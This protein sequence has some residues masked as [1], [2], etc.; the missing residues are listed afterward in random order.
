MDEPRN[1]A[2][3]ITLFDGP[4]NLCFGCSPF[5]ERGLRLVW[6][7]ANGEVR[8]RY[9]VPH[10]M[11]GAPGVAHG[12]IQAAL[13]DE[14]LGVAIHTALGEGDDV[15]YVTADF[16]LRYRRPVMTGVPVE[17]AGRLERREG[18]NHFVAGEI[19]ALDGSVLT[20]ATARWVEL[21]SKEGG[22]A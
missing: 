4:D 6:R 17:I 18:R 20:T 1:S 3:Q 19:V 15:H 8:A 2:S 12:G 5:N 14:T 16:A 13:L 10:D 22:A 21:P 11:R 7:R 9:T